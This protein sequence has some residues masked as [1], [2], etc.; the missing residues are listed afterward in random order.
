MA[1]L[2]VTLL[3][4]ALAAFVMASGVWYL[5]ARIGTTNEVKLKTMSGMASL[6]SAYRS[7]KMAASTVL[8]ETSWE[9]EIEGYV[10]MPKPPGN[11]LVWSYDCNGNFA[12]PL[13]ACNSSARHAICLSGTSVSEVQFNGMK[14]ARTQ[15]SSSQLDLGAD[16]GGS[17]YDVA[18]PGAFPASVAL[19]YWMTN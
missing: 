10:S 12:L 5:D 8:P 18:T 15:M 1:H 6:S 11:G 19:T 16:C 3:A 13:A 7:Y 14:R 17:E 4:I 2:I 9:T